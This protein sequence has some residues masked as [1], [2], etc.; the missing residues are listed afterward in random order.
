MLS[1]PRVDVFLVGEGL[2]GLGGSAG[3]LESDSF[4]LLGPFMLDFM[5]D[6]PSGTCMYCVHNFKILTAEIIYCF[7]IVRQVQGNFLK[8]WDNFTV[9]NRIG[10]LKKTDIPSLIAVTIHA[11]CFSS[12]IQL[13]TSL[14][15]ATMYHD[16]ISNLGKTVPL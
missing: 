3:L 9:A 12:S 11:R 1:W 5:G 2:G 4:Q 15:I 10:L 6:T 7:Y 14:H 13:W 16:C 8:V